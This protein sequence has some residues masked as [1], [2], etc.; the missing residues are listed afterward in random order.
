[1]YSLVHVLGTTVTLKPFSQ[2]S[3]LQCTLLHVHVGTEHTGLTAVYKY[4]T[5]SS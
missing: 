5:K 2:H 4:A 1:M 3:L